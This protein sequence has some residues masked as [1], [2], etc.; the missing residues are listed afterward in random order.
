MKPEPFL[1]VLEE[2]GLVS[3]SVVGKIREKVAK[4]DKRLTSKSIL[5]Y[6][7][8]KELVTRRQAKDLLSSVLSV[9]A[10]AE[11]S[12]LGISVLPQMPEEPPATKGSI[13]SDAPASGDSTPTIAPVADVPAV[14]EA[15]PEEASLSSTSHAEMAAFVSDSM[16]AVPADEPETSTSKKKKKKKSQAKKGN[17]WD[18][19]LLL[20]G[21][22]GLIVLIASGALIYWLI[23][24]ESGDTILKEAREFYDGSSYTQA[25]KLYERF[26]E[27]YPSHAEY[28]EARVQ[29]GVARLW[30]ATESSTDYARALETAK[31]VLDNIQDEPAFE[32]AQEDF[33]SRLPFIA[34]SL[35]N[36]AEASDDLDLIKQRVDQAREALS[37]CVNTKFVPKQLRNDALIEQVQETLARVERS[38]QQAVD[39][40]D[41]L[42]KIAEA[43]EASDPA[44]A[45][46]LHR[47]LLEKHPGLINDESLAARVAEI[48]ASEKAVVRFVEEGRAAS[49]EE[50]PSKIVATLAL[51]ERGSTEASG[52]TGTVTVDADGAVYALDAADGRLLWRRFVG[53]GQRNTPVPLENDR[54]LVLGLAHNE[55]LCLSKSTGKLIWRQE[56]GE[57]TAAPVVAGDAVL[58]SGRSGKLHVVDLETGGLRGFVEFGQPL[59]SPPAVSSNGELIYLAGEHSSV[60]TLATADYSCL[61]V[62]FLGHQKGSIS[63]PPVPVLNKVVVTEKTGVATSRVHVLGTDENGV[64]TNE[65]ADSRVEGI[66]ATAPVA[67]GRRLGVLSTTGVIQVFDVGTGNKDTAFTRVAARDGLRGEPVARFAAFVDGDLWVAG[68]QLLKL[69]V[70]PTGNRLLVQ[71]VEDVHFGDTFDGP[72]TVIERV[73]IHARRPADGAGLV[74]SA[75]ETA[76]GRSLWETTLAVPLAGAPAVNTQGPRISATATSGAAFLLERQS[77]ARRVQ[78]ESQRAAPGADAVYDTV[79]DLGSGRLAIGAV[80]KGDALH[81]RPGAPRGA[82]RTLQLPGKLACEITAWGDWFVAPTAVGQVAVFDADSAKLVATPFAP[83]VGP[84]QEVPWIVPAAYD[85]GD[86]PMLVASDG[87]KKLYLIGLENEPAPHFKAAAEVNLAD[88]KLVGRLAVVGNQAFAVSDQGSLVTYALPTLEE[89]QPVSIGSAVSWGPFAVGGRLLLA[90]AGSELVCVEPGT[91]VAWRAP[92]EGRLPIGKP[93]DEGGSALVLSASELLR[94]DMQSGEVTGSVEL[95]QPAAFGPVGFN[96][97][98]VVAGHDGAL[99]VV[100][101]P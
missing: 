45:Y 100:D 71:D 79:A 56:I 61:G 96:R 78:D 63:V 98:L 37:L 17:E 44:E 40:R 46:A 26:V 32:T 19:P 59:R 49:T 84:G 91:G 64:I 76:S 22:G 55:L 10:S 2:R 97:R 72:L 13:V 34:E 43:I 35:A 31:S 12:I 23:N 62:Y 8:K 42:A 51:A 16:D 58:L 86:A 80:G 11:S 33:A 68:N 27:E 50:R 67:S 36:Q 6:L 54:L 57:R 39:L 52:V 70:V 28:S 89:G 48:A 95:D 24:R 47:A 90:T 29:L 15:E 82:I 1:D 65:V 87:S 88:A 14:P 21:G 18:S 7:V 73:V 92:L 5:K 41:G 53:A 101:K 93:L 83:P 77:F 66:V 60:Y 81:L 9:T 99:L 25:I 4:G 85:G 30:N 20:L 75:N 69:E 94:L 38:Q 74:V 3:A